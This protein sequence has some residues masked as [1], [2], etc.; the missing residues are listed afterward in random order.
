MQFLI[1]GMELSSHCITLHCCLNHIILNWLWIRLLYSMIEKYK[2]SKS[3]NRKIASHKST[4]R[5]ETCITT[6]SILLG[7]CRLKSINWLIFHRRKHK[8]HFQLRITDRKFHFLFGS[9]VIKMYFS[10]ETFNTI[11]PFISCHHMIH[12]TT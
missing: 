1:G 2:L 12:P 7:S 4:S 5:N 3:R 8:V 9:N 11:L 6:F 10:I